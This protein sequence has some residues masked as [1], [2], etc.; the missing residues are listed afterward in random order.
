[1]AE[2]LFKIINNIINMFYPHRHTIETS[3]N[4]NCKLLCWKKP[5]VSGNRWLNGNPDSYLRMRIGIRG[6]M[7]LL[8]VR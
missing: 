2:S 3:I 7:K 1:M 8:C 6:M 5:G 4:P